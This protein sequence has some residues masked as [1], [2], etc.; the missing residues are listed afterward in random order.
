MRF[1]IGLGILELFS[2]LSLWLT[3]W[4]YNTLFY[5]TILSICLVFDAVDMILQIIL[6]KRTLPDKKN[7]FGGRF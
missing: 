3:Q 2:F 7:R 6:F 5:W 1:L 4:E